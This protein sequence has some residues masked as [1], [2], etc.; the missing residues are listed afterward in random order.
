MMR[1]SLCATIFRPDAYPRFLSLIDVVIAMFDTEDGHAGF[2]SQYTRR[3]LCDFVWPQRS[4]QN[5]NRQ[6]SFVLVA[7]LLLYSMHIP[8]RA[9]LT[10][11]SL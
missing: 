7:I 9:L 8:Y 2:L 1:R 5:E 6:I 10:V 3:M 11:T 4:Q